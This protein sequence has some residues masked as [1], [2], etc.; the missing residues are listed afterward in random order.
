M[1]RR[2]DILAELGLTP[3][4]LHRERLDE[5][6]AVPE[7]QRQTTSPPQ[8]PDVSGVT[9][10]LPVGSMD[11]A[12]LKGAASNCTA[13]ALHEKRK[14]AVLGVGDEQAAEKLLALKR[15]GEDALA[16]LGILLWKL[17]REQKEITAIH[18]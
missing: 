2:A 11:W 10:A 14:Q 7:L 13:C 9:D 8:N 4:W 17:F 5:P 16:A 3:I 15:R 12:A 18:A 6:G 1:T